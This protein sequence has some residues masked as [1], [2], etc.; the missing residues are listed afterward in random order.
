MRRRHLAAAI[1][2]AAILSGS[3]LATSVGASAAAPKAAA[4]T[5]NSLEQMLGLCKVTPTPT[6]TPTTPTPAPTPTQTQSAGTCGGE[7]LTK[8]DGSPWVCSFDDEFNGTTLDTS[9]WTVQV[10]SNS[11]YTTGVSP[12]RAC[13]VNNPANVSVGGGDLSLTVLKTAATFTCTAP[14]LFGIPIDNFSTQY[15]AGEV[16]SINNFSQEYGRFEVRAKLPQSAVQGLQETLWLWPN[17]D[18]L[19]GNGEPESGEIDFA[20]FYSL[21]ENRD[22]PYLHYDYNASTVNTTTNTNIVTNETTCLIDPTQFNT[23]VVQWEPG[24]ITLSYNGNTCLVDNYQPS[25]V[26]SPAPFNQPFFL[27]L[28][29]A[30]GVNSNA[31]TTATQFPA[32][33]QIDYVRV[34][35]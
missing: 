22:I 35:K 18:K 32:T 16:T 4:A 3:I 10:T 11:D 8:P 7:Q 25:D 1:G 2:I 30:I 33:T 21:Y 6:P 15:T 14:T 20:E 24:Q 19:Y 9:K 5:C 17:N 13:Y 26:T 27:A 28:T 34:W 23:Y 29:Q 12:Y 31:P